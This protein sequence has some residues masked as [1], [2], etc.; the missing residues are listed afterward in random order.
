[1]KIGDNHV[2]VNQVLHGGLIASLVD[3]ASTAALYNTK[4]RKTGVS[5]NM[6]IK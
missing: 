3:G 6:N 2:N 1:M 4:I 5:V